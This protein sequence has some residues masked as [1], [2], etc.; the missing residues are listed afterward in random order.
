MK[1]ADFIHIHESID[2]VVGRLRV[3]RLI[4]GRPGSLQT[5]ESAEFE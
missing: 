3:N 1:S 4:V 5:K 2:F